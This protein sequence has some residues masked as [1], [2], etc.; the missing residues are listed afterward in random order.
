[1]DS[2]I[3][4]VY[5]RPLIPDHIKFNNVIVYEFDNS[6]YLRFENVISGEGVNEAVSHFCRILDNKFTNTPSRKYEQFFYDI[7]ETKD[8]YGNFIIHCKDLEPDELCA[9]LKFLNKEKERK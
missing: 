6:K 3:E 5:P 4:S 7:T 2:D 8:V 9:L 1:M